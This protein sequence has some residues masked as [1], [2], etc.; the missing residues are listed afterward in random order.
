MLPTLVRTGCRTLKR[1][2]RD[3]R[4]GGGADAYST[5]V[6]DN[7]VTSDQWGTSP[8]SPSILCGHPGHCNAILD[9]VGVRGDKTPPHR[10]LCALRPPPPRQ[11]HTRVSVRTTTNREIST[12]P[13]SKP[14]LDRHRACHDAPL[15]AR[16]ARTVVYSTIPCTIPPH[17]VSTARHACKPPPLGL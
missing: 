12:P 3:P 6:Q 11:L 13:P 2:R 9:A 1:G 4:R 5:L 16:F 8:P 17:V 7:T 14:P 15:E 10:L